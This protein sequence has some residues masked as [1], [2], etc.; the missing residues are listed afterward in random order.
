MAIT[1]YAPTAATAPTAPTAPAA[2]TAL[3][4]AGPPAVVA[5]RAG[6]QRA[7]P[8]RRT[9]GGGPVSPPATAVAGLARLATVG[10]PVGAPR[11]VAT[12]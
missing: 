5:K 1:S 11:H 12:G 8:G 9:D 7:S 3:P 6:T 4:A 2:P 10:Q